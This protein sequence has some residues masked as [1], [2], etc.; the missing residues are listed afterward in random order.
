M[1]GGKRQQVILKRVDEDDTEWRFV[2]DNAEL[3]EWNWTVI[4]YEYLSDVEDRK[5]F[6]KW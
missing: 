5:K 1:I 2:E 4:G 3:D 6:E